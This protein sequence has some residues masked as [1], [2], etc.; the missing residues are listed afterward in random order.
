MSPEQVRRDLTLERN[1]IVSPIGKRLVFG[2]LEMPSLSELRRAVAELDIEPSSSCIREIVADVR[3]LHA[4]P[5]NADALFQV[6]SQ[7]NLLE[8]A[9]PAVIP[10]RG[11]ETCGR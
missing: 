5:V 11:V 9:G 6:D 4:D 10:E 8:M 3:E 1:C 7:F 2:H